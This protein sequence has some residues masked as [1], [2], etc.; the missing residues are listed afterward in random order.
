MKLDLELEQLMPL[1]LGIS[2]FVNYFFVF[3]NCKQF[4]FVQKF[5]IC[6]KNKFLQSERPVLM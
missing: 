5:F 6:I 3:F 4:I 2:L 1:G